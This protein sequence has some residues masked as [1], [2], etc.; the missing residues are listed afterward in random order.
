MKKV[1]SPRRKPETKTEACP[2][3][4][5]E[6]EEEEKPAY[7]PK[8]ERKLLARGY[9]S[10]V[11]R[12]A[13]TFLFDRNKTCNLSSPT[14]GR[15][16]SMVEESDI[17]KRLEQA[18][19]EYISDAIIQDIDD[20]EEIEGVSDDDGDEK[21]ERAVQ[22]KKKLPKKRNSGDTVIELYTSQASMVT[23]DGDKEKF[24]EIVKHMEQRGKFKEGAKML[25]TVGDLMKEKK[26]YR[27]SMLL[28][29]RACDMYE[30]ASMKP[31]VISIRSNNLH[32]PMMHLELYETL[33][34]NYDWVTKN[35]TNMPSWIF[36]TFSIM[37]RLCAFL[38]GD[39]SEGADE[40]IDKIND[41]EMSKSN[42]VLADMLKELLSSIGCGDREESEKILDEL[43]ISMF[44]DEN[45]RQQFDSIRISCKK[46]IQ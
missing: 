28:Y 17:D 15:T 39:G 36:E 35:Q 6:E 20:I 23:F 3:A 21:T 19:M 37:L 10:V 41:G 29:D 4:E 43:D 46:Y 16:K 9:D 32:D 30:K 25:K 1:L 24:E 8:V 40:L 14:M 42:A 26:D 22:N 34:E 12:E 38:K 7:T 11:L 5:E 33:A 31:E 2:K 44:Q 18:Y 27:M 45:I 13:E